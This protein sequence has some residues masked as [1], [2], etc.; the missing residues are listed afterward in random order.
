MP[1]LYPHVDQSPGGAVKRARYHLPEEADDLMK[2]RYRIINVWR[3]LS[4][5]K[6]WPLALCDARSVRE[7]DMVLNDLVRR[8]YIGESYF[9]CHNPK[10]KWYYLGDQTRDEVAVLKIFDSNEKVDGRFCVHSSFEIPGQ[11]D[12]RES[13]EVRAMVFDYPRP[14]QN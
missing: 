14:D 4:T 13:V 6:A 10:H 11:V 1:V 7:E 2:G 3:P 8:N 12:E 9:I 5:V